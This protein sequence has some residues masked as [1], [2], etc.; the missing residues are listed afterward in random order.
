MR[1]TRQGNRKLASLGHLT[2]SVI[3]YLYL[4]C[5]QE[6]NDPN[7]KN[8]HFWRFYYSLLL[9]NQLHS[10]PIYVA[11]VQPQ[12]IPKDLH[13][14]LEV[15]HLSDIQVL[16]GVYERSVETLGKDL[17]S[18]VVCDRPWKNVLSEPTTSKCVWKGE[19]RVCSYPSLQPVLIFLPN[20]TVCL[21]NCEQLPSPSLC[22][23]LIWQA[24]CKVKQKQ[25][26]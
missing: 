4:P 1:T 15:H 21:R 12:N 20:W 25:T 19:C 11:R 10:Y 6:K 24:V 8:N 18:T 17:G 13:N 2:T 14:V 9:K 3:I 23:T 16:S 5:H 22:K 7:H 26:M